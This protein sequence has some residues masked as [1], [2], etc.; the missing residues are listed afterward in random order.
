MPRSS[1]TISSAISIEL[2]EERRGTIRIDPGE[3][4]CEGVEISPHSLD[5]LR[6]NL[7]GVGALNLV[8]SPSECTAL[9]LAIRNLTQIRAADLTLPH[10]PSQ[11]I[12]FGTLPEPLGIFAQIP[13]HFLGERQESR[14]LIAFRVPQFLA[15]SVAG[16]DR[17]LKN[18]KN[19]SLQRL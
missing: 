11:A 5:K 19:I 15:E 8:L 10:T 16:Y 14:P 2:F 18:R 3:P 12:P 6:L 4:G 13:L 1:I 17:D 9:L 7:D